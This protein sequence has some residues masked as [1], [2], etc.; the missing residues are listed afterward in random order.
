MEKMYINIP[1]S[2]RVKFFEFV[3]KWN[4]KPKSIT[5]QFNDSKYNFSRIKQN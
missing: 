5:L 3:V 1:W 4:K 2:S